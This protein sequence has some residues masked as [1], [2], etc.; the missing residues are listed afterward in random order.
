MFQ[1]ALPEENGLGVSTLT[2]GLTRSSQV[3]SPFGSPLRV[4]MTATE[5]VIMP[6]Y[7][8]AS[9]VGSTRLALTSRV[10]SGASEKATMSAGRPE[11]TARLWSP[12]AP[13]DVLNVTFLPAGV[14]WKALIS[15]V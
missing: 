13:K 10:T 2:P 15:A 1:R 11:A 8:L 12:E 9:Q 5:L 7:W 3:L 4:V 14:A 6:L